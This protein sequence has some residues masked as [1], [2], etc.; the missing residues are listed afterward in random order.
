MTEQLETER[1]SRLAERCHYLEVSV[2]SVLQD[3][4]Q[5]TATQNLLAAA[6]FQLHQVALLL[7]EAA[8]LRSEE[9]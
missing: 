1:L 5:T 9:I 8:A 4:P 3:G 7:D 2:H 6:R